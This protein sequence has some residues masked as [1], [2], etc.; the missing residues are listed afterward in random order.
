MFLVKKSSFEQSKSGVS[1]YLSLPPI[2]TPCPKQTPRRGAP[3]RKLPDKRSGAIREAG[4]V[5][6]RIFLGVWLYCIFPQPRVP[7]NL[8]LIGI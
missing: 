8:K 4:H 3:I 6:L 2:A 5:S 7:A 1:K